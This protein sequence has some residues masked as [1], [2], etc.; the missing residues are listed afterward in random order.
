MTKL[1][2]LVEQ[3]GF[4]L[5]L[6]S[7]LK[8]TEGK[9]LEEGGQTHL[10]LLRGSRSIGQLSDIVLGFERN[11]QDPTNKNL[12]CVRVLKN[13]FVGITGLHAALLE[14]AGEFAAGMLAAGQQAERPLDGRR[15]RAAA[16]LRR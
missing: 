12:L 4:G 9:S 3:L 6:V 10:N 13:R 15:F 8:D 14:L 16:T 7:H 5:I 2:S 11:Q 1:R